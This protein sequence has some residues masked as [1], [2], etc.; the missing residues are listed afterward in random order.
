[1]REMFD[2]YPSH[3]N[4]AVPQF[5]YGYSREPFVLADMI[6]QQ[7]KVDVEKEAAGARDQRRVT[8]LETH[9]CLNEG[10]PAFAMNAIF[11][12]APS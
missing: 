10:G 12:P 8:R 2:A 5:L 1:M 3:T 4:T 6:V 7:L 11:D 9:S